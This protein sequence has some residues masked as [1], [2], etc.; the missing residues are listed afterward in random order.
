MLL[1]YYNFSMVTL[2]VNTKTPVI[3]AK[4]KQVEILDRL[5]TIFSSY[6]GSCQRRVCA[7]TLTQD[8]LVG[9]IDSMW[10][11]CDVSPDV[12]STLQSDRFCFHSY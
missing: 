8:L 2:L 6:V 4:I 7:L 10:I 12:I 3:L 1:I 5:V 9:S 11:S